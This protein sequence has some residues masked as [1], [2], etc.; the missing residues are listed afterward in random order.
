MSYQ[1]SAKAGDWIIYDQRTE[2][3]VWL[4]SVAEDPHLS[5]EE[6]HDA[7]E[8]A[9]WENPTQEE[10]EQARWIADQRHAI[11]R[12]RKRDGGKPPPR[13]RPPAAP[14]SSIAPASLADA[15]ALVSPER[16][17][18]LLR[19]IGDLLRYGNPAEDLPP[20]A[21]ERPA[22]WC[23]TDPETRGRYGHRVELE[24][25][26]RAWMTARGLR[27]APR[28]GIWPEDL[29]G[30]PAPATTQPAL[31]ASSPTNPLVTREEQEEWWTS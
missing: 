22:R 7:Y 8:R 16:G 9:G 19:T 18:A 25:Q 28:L 5:R 20:Y 23:R 27:Y 10:W 24:R 13:D 17:A 1:E 3:F 6:R 21:P 29:D 26:R 31:P 2:A 11:S 4:R 12:Q 15:G 14:W 30:P